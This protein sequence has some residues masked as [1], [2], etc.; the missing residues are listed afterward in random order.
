MSEIPEIVLVVEASEAGMRLDAFLA[1]RCP[2]LSRNRIEQDIHA[3][4]AAVGGVGRLKSHRLKE[5]EVVALRPVARPA[6]QAVAQ[7]LPLSVVYRDQDLLIIDKAPGMVVHPSA[8][9][10][11][12]TVVNAVLH[13][14][15]SV[16][17]GTDP[18]RPGIVHRL[19]RDTS[20]LL[21]VALSERAHRSLSAQLQDRR[22]GRMYLALS[23]GRWDPYQGTLAGD[24]GRHPRLRQKM[25]VVE[26]CGR[27]AATHYRV[28]ED[29]G[30]VQ[31]CRV[32]L[33]SGRT[34]QIRVHFAHHGHPV[35]GD[36]LYGDDQRVRG[37]HNLD[38]APAERMLKAVR[39]VHLH[40]A[41]LRLEHPLDGRPLTFQAPVPADLQ[42]VL[43]ILRKDA[44]GPT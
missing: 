12:G 10:P 14:C 28:L 30:F 22:M 43:D 34:H 31:H 37:L 16:H 3:G 27:P 8:G 17:T 44:P 5:G 35:V 26:H 38:R 2:E 18:L 7:D 33:E 19:D 32:E 20:G 39:R 42:T 4:R 15:G 25:A 11:G 36:P 21:A 29:F 9:H 41:E 6:L 1:A 23:W 40:A 13:L 24:I